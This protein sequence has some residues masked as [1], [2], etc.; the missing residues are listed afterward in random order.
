LPLL[1]GL[2]S[3]GTI[4]TFELDSVLNEWYFALPPIYDILYGQAYEYIGSY[5]IALTPNGNTL[6]TSG[7]DDFR[8]F[9]VSVYDYVNASSWQQRGSSRIKN[10]ASGDSDVTITDD[11]NLIAIGMPDSDLMV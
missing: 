4:G 5:S 3:P 9:L 11:G 1:L 10:G 8:A 2:E 6:V 7:E